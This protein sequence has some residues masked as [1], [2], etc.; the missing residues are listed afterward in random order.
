MEIKIGTFN[1]NNLFSRFNFRFAAQVEAKEGKVD[2]TAT[3]QILETQMLEP[4]NYSGRV[5]TN[6]SP[7]E[8]KKIIDRIS[9]MDLDIVALQEVE[10]IGTLEYFVRHELPSASAYPFIVLVEGNDPRMIDVALISKLPIGQV[11]SWRH[12]RRPLNP[13]EHIFSRDLLQVEVLKPNG[14]H[15][16]TLFNTHLKSKYIPFTEPNPEQKKLDDDALRFLQAQTMAAIIKRQTRPDSRYVVL[17]DFNDEP[18]AQTLAPLA[19]DVE[20]RL[21]NGLATAQE[22]RPFTPINHP[23]VSPVWTHRYKPDKLPPEYTLFDQ[24]WLSPRLAE[25]QT[26]AV[27][28]RRKNST[29]DGS[30]HDPAYVTIELS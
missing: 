16:L 2:L 22:T 29:G 4:T 5:V 30:D 20:L 19:Q 10:D 15:A 24:I 3:K 8:R 9:A 17:G 11:S 7:V 1:V 23:P 25:H 14:Q 6:K 13:Q 27:I 26:G 18:D 28:Q 12:L 21:V